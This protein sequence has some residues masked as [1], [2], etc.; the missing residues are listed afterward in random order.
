MKLS[1]TTLS[2]EKITCDACIIFTHGRIP[3]L[4]TD[5]GA[6]KK[7]IQQRLKNHSFSGKTNECIKLETSLLK[8]K[9]IFSLGPFEVFEV[10][11]RRKL[12]MK[13]RFLP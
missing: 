1:T 2:L 5:S 12:G 11:I 13:E 9:H 6:L 3:L 7:E 8:A 4:K 10:E